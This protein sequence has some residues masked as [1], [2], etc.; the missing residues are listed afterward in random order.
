MV[1]RGDGCL[2]LHFLLQHSY[3]AIR[4]K[5]QII[6]WVCTYILDCEGLEI[7]VHVYSTSTADWC[8]IVM[9]RM[10][11]RDSTA[12]RSEMPHDIKTE[13]RTAAIMSTAPPH[14]VREVML[15]L[16]EEGTRTASTASRQHQ[17]LTSYGCE[18]RASSTSTT[19]VRRGNRTGSRT[20]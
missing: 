7:E 8:Q 11:A 12:V 4:K 20:R 5:P 17:H 9:F 16:V 19:A 6:P 1:C 14:E 15:R 13:Y 10:A 2:Q 3:G 18:H